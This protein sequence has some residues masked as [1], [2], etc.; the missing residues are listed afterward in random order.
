MEQ[1]S[2]SNDRPSRR[3]DITGPVGPIGPTGPIGF[4][5]TTGAQGATGI[6]GVTGIAGPTGLI[7]NSIGSSQVYQN[8]INSIITLSINDNGN[9]YTGS[10]FFCQINSPNYTPSSYGYIVTAAHVIINPSN[11]QVSTIIWI[12]LTH[13]NIISF[14]LNGTNAVVM[15]VD[16]IADI[17]LI[18]VN[19]E[20]YSSLHLPVKNSRT[21]L[22]IGEYINVIGFPQGSDPQSITRGI[23]RDNKFQN[24]S[25]PES[26]YTDASIYGGNSGGPVITDSNHVIGILS[27][28]ITNQENLNGAVASYL[29]NPI[30]TYICTNYVNS[31]ISYPKGYLGIFYSNVTF[32]LAMTYGIKIEGIRV[33]SLDTTIT[34][35]KFNVFDIITEVEGIRIGIYNNQSPFF[36]EIHL[37]P[38]GTVINV[39]YL[40][41][42]SGTNTYGTETTKTVTLEVFNSANDIFINNVHQTPYK[43]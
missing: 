28:G 8:S 5:G 37:R 17:A 27:W 34:P 18:R 7:G 26:V 2:N 25:L 1:Y 24:S 35:S 29:F 30:L 14:Q 31:I 16:K 39:K 32:V 10:G 42:N 40:P 4:P 22:L 13:P 20:I 19:S 11:N 3:R 38:P 41:Y 33:D 12:H 36:T 21:Q 6:Q 23:V 9:I 15:G 43:I